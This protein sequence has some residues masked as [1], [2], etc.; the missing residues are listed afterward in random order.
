MT[1][2][3]GNVYKASFPSD[4]DM[5]IFSNNGNGKT[6]DLSIPG[7]SM[8]YDGNEW[9]NYFDDENPTETTPTSQSGSAYYYGDS[10]TDG[11]VNIN[12]VTAIQ[13]HL[14]NIKKLSAL[15]ETLANIDYDAKVSIKDANVIQCMLVG[16]NPQANRVYDV[17]SD[18]QPTQPTETQSN[19]RMVYCVNSYNWS[20]LKAYFWSDSNKNMME[21]PGKDMVQVSGNI[22]AVEIP[23][24]A[25]KVIFTEG[26][27]RSQTS[28]LTIPDGAANIY[29]IDAKN[30]IEYAG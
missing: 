21:W 14:I 2:C 26:T 29:N 12:D 30:W 15:G 17:Y 22:F 5:C 10:N 3:N 28:D 16:I 19:K 4:N 9:K 27:W 25:T 13:F 23:D 20:P 18:S 7:N 11:K 8:I 1:K 6:G 24:G